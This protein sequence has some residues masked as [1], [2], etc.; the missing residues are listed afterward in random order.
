MSIRPFAV[1]AALILGLGAATPRT[2]AG[3][4]GTITGTVTDTGGRP[5]SVAQIG[6]EGTNLTAVSAENGRFTVR[7]VPSG[8]HRIS[9]RR[10][11]FS[12]YTQSDVVVPPGGTVEVNVRLSIAV[13]RLQNMVVTATSDPI[14]GVRAPFSVGRVT[15]EDIKSV[16]TTNSAAAAIQGKV[17]GVNIIR[18]SGQPGS[19]VSVQLRT[20]VNFQRSNSPMYVVD[21]VILGSTFSGTTVDL[22]ALDIETIEVV[23]GAAAASL[24]GSRAANGVISITTSRGAGL[25]QGQTRIGYR[26]EFGF[27]QAPTNVNVSKHHEFLANSQG[28]YLDTLGNIITNLSLRQLDPNRI[29]DNSYAKTY[30]NIGTFFKPGGFQTHSVNFAQN[31]QA[32]N[33]LIS[34]NQKHERGSLQQNEG[35]LQRSGRVNLD[36]RM[37]DAVTF[38]VSAFHSRNTQDPL[39]GDPF[40]GLLLFQPDIDLGKR[41]EDGQLLPQPDPLYTEREN[42]IWRQASRFGQNR[43]ARTLAS[44]DGRYAPLSWLTLSSNLSYDRSDLN[45]EFYLPKGTPLSITANNPATGQIDEDLTN[46]DALNGSMSATVLQ[47]I[48]GLTARLTSTG[49]AERER[50]LNV[51]ARG[52]DLFVA[53]VQDLSIAGTRTVSSQLIEIRANAFVTSLGL[54][55]NGKYIVDGLVRRDGSSLFGPGNRWNTYYRAST[56]YRMAE[57]PW[58]PF[59]GS[60]NEFKLRYSIGTAG[61]RPGFS[62]QYETWTVNGSTGAVTKERLGNKDLK[63][64]HTT[65][66]EFGVDMI[67]RDRYSLE[68][69]Y[70]RQVTRDQITDVQLPATTGYQSQWQNTG[71]GEGRTLE[72]TFQA[73]VMDRKDFSWSTT[74]VADRSRSKIVEWNT[75]CFIDNLRS[76]CS[77]SDLAGM[78]GMRLIR[79]ADQLPAIH[80]S[81][82]SRAKFQRNDDGFL[83]PVGAGRSWQDRL[84][85]T[86]VDV[87][88]VKYP[89]GMPMV[90]PFANGTPDGV[91]PIGNSNAD[92][93]V[94]WLNNFRYRNLSLHAQLHSQI[95]GGVY[96]FTKQRMY[97]LYRHGDVDQF[98]KAEVRK[99]PISYYQTVYNR[100]ENTDYFIEDASYLKLRELALSYRVSKEMLGRVGLGSFAP[101]G[102]TMG[103]IG[104]N[105]WTLTKYSGWDPEVGT[106]TARL[107][108]FNYP[109]TRTLTGSVEISF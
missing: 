19:G 63:P 53:D 24:Y 30:D 13:L 54:D 39:S 25:P 89:W 81:A 34:L 20:P 102:L 3:Q 78:N 96:N 92:A 95:G 14:E 45:D 76:L 27:S 38:Q 85:G 57:E 35:F 33:F 104:R 9:V 62:D 7:N 1:V 36:H 84:W 73:Q 64:S 80:A 72:A 75:R 83:V 32:T 91:F 37:G 11:G 108:N 82:E 97:Q 4:A 90:Q 42:P 70:V 93:N 87:D 59:N 56:A 29:Q 6:V 28:Q 101:D 100:A 94:G 48:G 51:F 58:W 86:E 74:V 10:V 40:S 109:N 15:S 50:S 52:T 105:L 61:S 106:A 60:L 16:P 99:K 66:Q 21:G 55:Y 46:T 31:A 71:I 18:S 8:T 65:E 26:T 23:K 2:A 88:G 22:E 44:V 41:G 17:A 12:P 47:A 67:F 68:L 5:I 69:S 103:L 98:G 77:G 79:N 43:R 49:I 107:D